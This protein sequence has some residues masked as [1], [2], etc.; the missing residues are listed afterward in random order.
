MLGLCIVV[1]VLLLLLAVVIA[2]SHTCGCA[3]VRKAL[4]PGSGFPPCQPQ[5]HTKAYTC[6]Y[7]QL[8]R[9]A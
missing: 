5:V 7:K 9:A 3:V 6:V 1:M 2:A 8:L 4:V